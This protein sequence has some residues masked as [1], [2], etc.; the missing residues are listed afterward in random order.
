MFQGKEYVYAVY[1][2]GG[3]SRAARK[4]CISQPS[5]SANVKRIENKI[6]YPLFDRAGSPVKLT[7]CGEK[8]IRSAKEIMRVETE[9]SDYINDLGQLR[10][11][12][13]ALGAGSLYAA[14]VLPQL[15]GA[16]SGMYP[17][18]KVDLLE[19]NTSELALLLQTGRIDL[20][21]DNCQLDRK[22]YECVICREEV[23]F[24]AVSRLLIPEPVRAYEVPVETIRD[25]TWK[26]TEPSRFP[27]PISLRFRLYC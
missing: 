23:L 21:L 19:E 12:S 7:E 8:Y 16:F 18:I 13:L 11:G 6:G 14:W 24:L 15:L 27:S 1:E 17:H 26:K 9:F 5:L 10:T 25:G 4:L 22:L 3:F 2:E 20:M